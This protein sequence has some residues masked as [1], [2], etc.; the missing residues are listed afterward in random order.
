MRPLALTLTGFRSHRDSTDFAFADRSLIA[1]VGPTGAGKSSILDGISFALYGKTP[2]E[3]SAT[4]SLIC[5]RSNRA[6]VTLRFSVDGA[7]YEITRVL[8]HKGASEHVLVDCASGESISGEGP[9][10]D[11][12]Q[13][14][15]GLDFDA[16]CSSVLLAQ[17][18]FD[19]FLSAKPTA[20]T[21]ILKSLF[22]LE[23]IED[24]RTAA[25]DR[26][27][28]LDVDIARVEGALGGITPDAPLRLAEAEEALDAAKQRS[29]TLSS[30]LPDEARLLAAERTAEE[31]AGSI[32]AEQER[33]QHA[34]KSLPDEQT[35]RSFESEQTQ[36]VAAVAGAERQVVAAG[37]AQEAAA[38]AH[39][40]LEGEIGSEVSLV[41]LQHQSGE[42]AATRGKVAAAAEK[43]AAAESALSDSMAEAKRADAAAERAAAAAEAAAGAL[44]E[45]ER[46]HRAHV[47]REGLVAG[48]PCPVCE[49]VVATLPATTA[50]QGLEDARAA[51]KAAGEAAREADKVLAAARRAA[52]KAADGLERHRAELVS[53]REEEVRRVTLLAAEL[54]EVDDYGAEIERRLERLAASAGT[55]AEATAAYDQAAKAREAFREELDV[56]AGTR[57]RYFGA[58]TSAAVI[59]GID[60]PADDAAPTLVAV[61]G[62][63]RTVVAA[64]LEDLVVELER[65]RSSAA[66]VEHELREL[67]KGLGLEDGVTVVDGL[68]AARGDER[69]AAERIEALRRDIERA[70]E[71]EAERKAF[72]ARRGVYEQLADDMRDA[73]FVNFLLAER[74]AL[75]AEL[76]SERFLEMTGRYRFARDDKGFVVIDELAADQDRAL[77]SLS[78]G[79]TFLASLALAL[80]LADLVAR[81]GGRLQCFFLDEGFGSLDPE[82]F[83]DAMD[84]IEQL[85]TGDRL[86]GLVSHVPALAERVEDKIVLERSADG[87]TLVA[88][89]ADAPFA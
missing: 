23:R 63:A 74:S 61:A 64:R 27:R 32:V 68:A 6:H 43:A 19:Q 53:L 84:G 48:E 81:E 49:Q 11:R 3:K 9:V 10:N 80:A 76:A 45:L 38:S 15:L 88:A 51:S 26:C 12:V 67:R 59:A 70:K 34:D 4:K 17:G 85:V 50:P 13:E 35:L 24:V 21:Q 82:S 39:A 62:Q 77:N 66:E 33:L 65:V 58:V 79:E 60:P 5:N 7:E 25:K 55:V 86:I 78:G 28:S 72:V 46:A 71:L 75:L 18:R 20:R 22:R 40:A 47:L 2:R 87:T 1:I 89:G 69:H 36:L 57:R 8:P 29:R 37:A 73:R 44:G 54:G 56:S 31:R 14:L 16:F 30:A 52:E 41:G 42:L 83:D